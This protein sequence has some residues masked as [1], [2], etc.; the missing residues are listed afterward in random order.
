MYS[1]F[2]TK[3]IYWQFWRLCNF[4]IEILNETKE[5]KGMFPVIQKCDNNVNPLAQ[6]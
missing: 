1:Q 3:V 4:S 2:L 5:L 6:I